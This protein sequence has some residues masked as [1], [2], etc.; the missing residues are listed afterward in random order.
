MFFEDI[1]NNI[2]QEIGENQ[3]SLALI[4]FL[5]N[6][7]FGIR[8]IGHDIYNYTVANNDTFI[9]IEDTFSPNYK[10]ESLTI[11]L[12]IPDIQNNCGIFYMYNNISEKTREL[13]IEYMWHHS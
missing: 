8:Q 1:K 9:R 4:N 6:G 7:K 10:N 2:I 3:K 11:Y 12:I 13:I 5:Q